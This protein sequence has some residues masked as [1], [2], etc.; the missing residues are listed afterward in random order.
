MLARIFH[1]TMTGNSDR[2][3][4]H[5]D[6]RSCLIPHWP[7]EDARAFLLLIHGRW[8]GVSCPGARGRDGSLRREAKAISLALARLTVPIRADLIG[9]MDMLSERSAASIRRLIMENTEESND[10][11]IGPSVAP[12]SN[13]DK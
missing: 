10:L 1:V 3:R 8:T 6:I 9:E 2:S 12:A 13:G 7:D 5:P 11:H 4:R